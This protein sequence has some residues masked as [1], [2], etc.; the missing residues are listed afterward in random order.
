MN[1]APVVK[2]EDS[3]EVKYIAD[4]ISD[5]TLGEMGYQDKDNFSHIM[6][7]KTYIRR[8]RRYT[9]EQSL[10]VAMKYIHTVI[11]TIL[12]RHGF[13][14]TKAMMKNPKIVEVV[15]A[16]KCRL[17]IETRHYPPEDEVYQTGIYV[18]KLRKAG[19]GDLIDHEIVGFVSQPYKDQDPESKIIH[20]NPEVCV[21]STEKL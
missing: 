18:I 5:Q 20:F 12:N 7:H 11:D 6:Q 21:R 19:D 4:Y 17:R 2:E 13:K 3:P 9:E 1:K 16:Q 10:D 14:M 15:L 8:F